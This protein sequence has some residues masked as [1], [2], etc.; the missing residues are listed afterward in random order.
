MCWSGEFGNHSYKVFGW[1]ALGQAG[2]RA[3]AGAGTEA[4]GAAEPGAEARAGGV[5]Q[6]DVR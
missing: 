2:A 3:R 5:H 4:G 1:E 6:A